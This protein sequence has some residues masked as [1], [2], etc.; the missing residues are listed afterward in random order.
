MRISSLSA[1]VL[2]LLLLAANPASGQE[3]ISVLLTD[4][5]SQRPVSGLAVVLTNSNLSINERIISDS[6]GRVRFQSVPPGPGYKITTPQSDVYNSESVQVEAYGQHTLSVELFLYPTQSIDLEEAVVLASPTTRINRTDS[7]VRFELRQ[8]EIR[9]LPIEGRDMTRVLF[10]LP[11]VS[12]ATGFYPEA[13]NVSINGANSLYTS[14]LIDG[15][16]NNERFLGG[17]KFAMPVGATRNLTVLTNNYSSEYGLTANGV[18]NLT[19]RAGTNTP[20]GEVFLIHRPGPALDG[21]PNAPQRDLSG[22]PV[23]NGFKRYQA[24]FGAG[25]ALVRDRTFYYINVEHTTDVKDN[26]LISP[27]LGVAETIR[28]TNRMTYLSARIDQHWNARFR[29]MLRVNV[30]QTG[31]EQ[32]GGG[33]EGG[34]LF[35][36]AGSVQD[37]NALLVASTHSY[38]NGPFVSETAFQFARFRWN[39]ARPLSGGGPQVTLL[40][41][42]ELPIA[43]I[44]HPGFTFD[45]TEAS[46][47]VKQTLKYY[48][49]THTIKAGVNIISSAHSLLGGGNPAGNY[50]VK[51]TQPQIDAIRLSGK[52]STL[53][54]A[55]IPASAEVLDYAVELRPA[56]IDGQQTVYSAFVEDRWTASRRLTITAGIRYDFDNLTASGGAPADRDNFSPRLNA[57]YKL[58]PKS[59]IRGGY[60][61]FYDKIPYA[62][63]SDALQ[64]STQSADFTR[65]LEALIEQGILP[66]DTNLDDV[67]Y[68]GN[69]SAFS[70][71]VEYLQGPLPQ[72]LAD[73]R[74]S[75]FSNERRILNPQGLSNP[76]S[77]Q[78]TIGYQ[79]QINEHATFFVDLVHNRSF[80]LLRLRNLNAPQSYP[81]TDPDAT[82]VRSVSTA[83]SSRPVP[84]FEGGY[85][86]LDGQQ[87]SGIARNV[88]LS[89]SEGQSRYYA[90][91]LN[92][93]KE[94]GTD[95]YAIRIN[96]TL[97][98]LENNTEDINFRA[99]DANNFEAEW[100]PSINDRTHIISG[101]FNWFPVRRLEVHIASLFQ[102]GQPINRVPDAIEFGT[103]DL[104]GDGASFGD[105]YLGNS[106]R[107]P[108]ESRNNDRLP[109]S[110][111]VDVGLVYDIPIA[112]G[113]LLV[114]ADVFNIFNTEN[115]SGYSN[116]ATQ[117]NQIQTGPA[118]SGLLVRR[119][120][121]PPRQ[122][123]LTLNYVW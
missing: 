73:Q 47:Q 66:A 90:A 83:D 62:V 63:Y 65:Q 75:I 97:S 64:Q 119:N 112:T 51:L 117:S 29:S 31:I 23:L 19:S 72:E 37:R 60:G 48:L 67:T 118:A 110:Q 44:G 22:N 70:S 102:S 87:V 49:P 10:R 94:R 18:V 76:Y 46:F 71:Q 123:Q 28:G 80:D 93:S 96:Y 54:P 25:G 24:G 16:D 99:M 86:I 21:R 56:S 5:L 38:L 104:N 69:L 92:Y 85:T 111:T 27:D 105:A 52:G 57:N 17:Q 15:L 77:H 53:T 107:Y 3:D 1:F 7:E 82:V 122:F 41:P 109:W 11:N 42:S 81:L 55:D 115:L 79:I 30:G 61:L 34:V 9:Q 39:Y 2:V 68:V 13:P 35:P 84:V 106:D 101:I 14:Y 36:G 40:N 58:G 45:Q 100:G 74:E 32:Q 120:Y 103:A 98:Y 26:A 59:A 88:I 108:G 8:E 50:R 113:N 33:L 95:D 20:T 12:Q 116:N 91:S 121:G 114:R 4:A 78:V 89:E 6:E 43:I